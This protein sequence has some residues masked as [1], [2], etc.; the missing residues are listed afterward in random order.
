MSIL[1]EGTVIYLALGGVVD[2]KKELRTIEGK[3]GALGKAIEAKASRLR[4]PEFIKKAPVSV[5]TKEKETLRDYTE[6]LERLKRMQ[7]ELR[8]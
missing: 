1:A 6:E 5:V 2:Q 4:N 7:D 3:M 8:S